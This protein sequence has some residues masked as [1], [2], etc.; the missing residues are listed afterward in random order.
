MCN[1]AGQG[2]DRHLFA[3]KVLAE[4]EGL[5][6][7][8]FEDPCYSYMNEII[9][10]TST[11]SSNAVLLGGFA[12]VTP[13]GFGVGY[14]VQDNWLGAQVATYPTHNGGDFVEHLQQVFDDIYAVLNGNSFK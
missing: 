2:F 7:P 12:P 5:Q 4:N 10:S 11:L 8:L 6:V 13:N 3:L 1:T 9:L 14:G